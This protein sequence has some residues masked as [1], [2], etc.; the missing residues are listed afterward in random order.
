MLNERQSTLLKIAIKLHLL[1][2]L[3]LLTGLQP[4]SATGLTFLEIP[5]GARET[6]LG[7]AG[8]ALWDGPTAVAYNPAATAFTDRPGV[9]LMHNRHFGDTRA[10]FVGFSMRKKAITVTPHF[11]GTRVSDIE[12]R[13]APTSDPISTFDATSAVVG[14]AAAWRTHSRLAAGVTGRYIHQK[15]HFESSEGW[16]ADAGVLYQPPLNGLAL[17]LAVNHL[18]HVSSFLNEEPELPTSLRGGC[19]WTRELRN[20]GTLLLTADAVGVRS[21]TP[22]FRGGVEFRAPRYAAFRAGWVE[23]LEAQNL[24][25]GVGLF[26]RSWRL[27]Y[28]FVPYREELGEGHRFSLGFDL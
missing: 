24:S 11:W 21:K 3:I 23:G 7:G 5:V 12:Y 14:A 2:I 27:D 10:Q 4:V 8:A 15:I 16:L 17:G 25:F 1:G 13:N 22:L 9:A 26:V 28:A 18:G 19:S 20:A 6:A